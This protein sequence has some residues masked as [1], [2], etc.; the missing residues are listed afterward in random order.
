MRKRS[1]SHL[2]DTIFWFVIYAL[3]LLCYLLYFRSGS[4]SDFVTFMSTNLGF[5]FSDS[6]PIFTAI[7]QLFGAD[8][9]LPFFTSAG[10]GL[11]Y[12][13][14]WFVCSFIVHLAVDFV[15]FIPRL[16]HKW[17]CKST[18]GD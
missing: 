2:A 8:G 5:V 3:P 14:T 7:Q 17:L 6:N 13:V 1:I 9:I 4:S 15:L 12:M 11:S 10:D 18:Q 16:A